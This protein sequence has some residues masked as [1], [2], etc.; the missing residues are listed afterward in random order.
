MCLSPIQN[1]SILPHPHF[2]TLPLPI[3]YFEANLRLDIILFI[4][5]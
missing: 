5:V 2:G 3:N 4:N 1:P